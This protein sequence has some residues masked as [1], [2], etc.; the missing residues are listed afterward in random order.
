MP[1]WTPATGTQ[2]KTILLDSE[3]PSGTLPYCHQQFLSPPFSQ[4]VENNC[5]RGYQKIIRQTK[6]F[7][8]RRDQKCLQEYMTQISQ[9]V[10]HGKCCNNDYL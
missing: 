4:Q 9:D 7:K 6:T 3:L 10:F 1:T 8:V 5:L 2:R